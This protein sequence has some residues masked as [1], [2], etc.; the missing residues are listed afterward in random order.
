MLRF[1]YEEF[2]KFDYLFL[3]FGFLEMIKCKGKRKFDVGFLDFVS[4]IVLRGK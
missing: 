1:F 3:E 2:E 4:N